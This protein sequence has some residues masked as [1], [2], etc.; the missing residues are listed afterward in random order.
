MLTSDEQNNKVL[1]CSHLYLSG[2]PLRLVIRSLDP[3]ASDTSTDLTH[4]SL[5][6]KF[7]DLSQIFFVLLPCPTYQRLPATHIGEHTMYWHPETNF[8]SKE[9]TEKEF[10]WTFITLLYSVPPHLAS[11]CPFSSSLARFWCNLQ[12]I[13]M[14]YAKHYTKEQIITG[15]FK[16]ERNKNRQPGKRHL[17]DFLARTRRYLVIFKALQCKSSKGKWSYIM[18]KH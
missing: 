17:I 13:F 12:I 15:L 3:A 10:Q 7:S 1:V 6:S 14:G 16:L 9:H 8:I 11:S 4:L 5:F 18:Q 2:V